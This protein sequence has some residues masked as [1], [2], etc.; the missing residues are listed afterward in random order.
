MTAIQT[1]RRTPQDIIMEI[2]EI[3]KKGTR[4]TRIMYTANLSFAQNNK[5]LKILDDAGLIS[6]KE[7]TW[8]TTEKGLNIMESCKT[9]R[10]LIKQIQPQ[11][12]KKN[13]Q[14]PP[15]T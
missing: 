4:K 1:N 14:I 9:C 3:G 6:K 15:C 11:T 10:L 8:K 5:Y 12:N 7:N 13:N 2:L